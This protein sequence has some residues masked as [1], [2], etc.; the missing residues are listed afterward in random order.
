M[1]QSILIANRGEIALRIIWACRE[2]GIKTVAVYSEADR[3]SLHVSFADEAICIGPPPASG[4][5]LNV[6]AVISAAEIMGVDAIHPGYGFLAEN[7]EFAEICET[8]G[9][10]F[11][12][13]GIE[14]IRTMGD[15]ALA[16]ATMEAA[17]LPLIRGSDGSVSNEKEAAVHADDIG[18]PV[19]LKAAAGGG[20]KGMRVVLT[21]EDLPTAFRTAG[22]EA[23]AAF[24]SGDVYVE[25]YIAR[26]RHIEV[27]LL[28]DQHGNL[29]HLGERECS[30]QRKYQKLVEETPAPALSD[31]LRERIWN[32][33][34]E[35][36]RHIG[37]ASAG[38]M[39][40]LVDADSKHYFMEMNTRIQ[41]EHPITEQVTLVDLIK[42]QI[43]IA[44]GKKLPFTQDDIRFRG[45]SI[46]CRVNAEHPET[47]T[48]SPGQI[49]AFNVPK[50]L[51]VRVDTAAHEVAFISPYYDSLIAK[52]IVHA[53]NR[54]EA[55]VRIRRALGMF[56][57]QGIDTSLPLLQRIMEHPG[58]VAVDYDTHL[59][60][61]LL[62]IARR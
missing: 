55:L 44:A 56:V 49:T 32:D 53:F 62:P 39:E 21:R 59:I 58:F 54:E 33:A 7:A 61:E 35:G 17:G 24:G 16:R 9:L 1:F 4:S 28:G 42:Q 31:G 11:I 30:V 13:P 36:A 26:P 20:G 22:A 3:D 48:P 12:G 60:E 27:Q 10:I 57:I 25:K 45:H 37:Y 14:T 5:Y 23:E 50:G 29:V 2:L 8:C 52:V 38:T 34:L 6:P 15:K 43:R 47:L 41:V 40:F 51:G 19:L 18:Y 46:E